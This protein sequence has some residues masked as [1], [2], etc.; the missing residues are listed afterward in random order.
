MLSLGCTLPADCG[1]LIGTLASERRPS[2]EDELLSVRWDATVLPVVVRSMSARSDPSVAHCK[3]RSSIGTD[4][5]P[6]RTTTFLTQCTPYTMRTDDSSKP[7]SCTMLECESVATSSAMAQFEDSWSYYVG[8]ID[9]HDDQK[10]DMYVRL[11]R[12]MKR[13]RLSAL[14]DY[15]RRLGI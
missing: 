14:R 13:K 6:T 11:Y 7:K 4:G 1:P 12:S 3:P 8:D 9:Y 5:G 2:H 15:R 10:H